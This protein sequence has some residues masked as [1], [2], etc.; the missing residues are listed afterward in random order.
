M[1]YCIIYRSGNTEGLSKC[2][3]YL[4]FYTNEFIFKIQK[5]SFIA[6]MFYKFVYYYYALHLQGSLCADA[7]EW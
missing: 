6:F 7:F 3:F 5:C 4:C 1:Y 2:H